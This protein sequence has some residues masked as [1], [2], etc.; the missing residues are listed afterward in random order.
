MGKQFGG[1]FANW[2]GKVGNVVGRDVQGRTVL[3]IYQP[4]V[5]N[6]RTPAQVAQRNDF[7]LLSK[8]MSSVT[9]FLRYGFHYLDGYKTGNYYSSAVGYNIKRNV[10]TGSGDQRE[11]L[12]SNLILSLGKIDLPYSPNAI[13]EGV[14][15]MLTWSDNSGLGNAEATDK[16]MVC[17]WNMNTGL[18]VINTEVAERAERNATL[19]LPTNWTGDN[20]A[21]F[22]A[23]RRGEFECSDSRYIDSLPL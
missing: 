2:N 9:E 22:I 7:S 20:V 14:T 5:R 10:F 1:V 17:A 21:V 11:V 8:A 13:V 18:S 4:N 16:V 6:P 23:M 3:A 19:T 15:L 12:Y